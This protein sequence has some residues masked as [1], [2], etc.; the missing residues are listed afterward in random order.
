MISGKNDNKREQKIYMRIEYC[1]PYFSLINAN[2]F[3]KQLFY[4]W[5]D[6]SLII[7]LF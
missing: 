1:K 4:N 2:C 5:N 7:P 3:A 6:N